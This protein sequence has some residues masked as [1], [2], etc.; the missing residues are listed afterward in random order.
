MAALGAG[1]IRSA[2]GSYQLAFWVAGALCV[3]AGISFLTAGARPFR[4][5]TPV[6]QAAATA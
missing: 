5:P 2:L 3:A 6:N 4:T 1:A